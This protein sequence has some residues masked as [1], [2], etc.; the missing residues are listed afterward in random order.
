MGSTGVKEYV[1]KINGVTQSVKDVTSLESAVKA[2]DTAVKEVNTN[3]AK[4]STASKQKAAAMTDEEKA[5]KKLA[6]TQK[7]IAAANSEANRAQIAATQELRE[8]TREITRQVAAEKLAEDSVKAMGM[9]LTDLRN[10][11][12]ALSAAERNEHEV[13]GVL[14]ERIQALDSEYK[15]LRES[16]GNF[17]DSV[18]HY[19]KAFSGL[20]E[21]KDRFELASRGSAN[22]A[23]EVVGTND[24]L[25]AFGSTTTTVAKSAEQLA[26]ITA[27]AT[28]AQEAYNAVVKEGWI[29]QQAAAVMDAVRAVQLKAKTAAEA[30]STK[31]TIAATVA[32]KALNIVANA[33]PYVLLATAIVTV[34]GALYMFANRT[35]NAAEKQK[36]LNEVQ[37]VFLDQ[38]ERE[39]N[40]LKEAGDARVKA[41]QNQLAVLQ[42]AG[43]KTNDIRAIEDKLA[44]EREAN[45]SRQRGFYAEE[46]DNLDKN[47][48]KLEELHDVLDQLKTAQASGGTK[49]KLDI[50]LDGKV[51]KVKVEDAINSVQGA[52]DN[53]GRKVKI[54]VDLQAEDK[55]IQQDIAVQNAARIKA[56]A[57]LAKERA[58]K[59][60]EAAKQRADIETTETRAAQDKR[61]ELIRDSYDK[62]QQ[63]IF[64][65]YQREIEDLQKKLATEKNLTAKA[66][67]AI[68]DQI[69][70]AEARRD[71]DIEKL[72][73]E[74]AVKELADRRAAE[75][76]HTALIQ[77]A[78]KR[79]ETEINIRYER[80]KHD[81]QLRLDTEEDLTEAQQKDITDQME[82]AQ[83][84]R[85]K[86]LKELA[87]KGLEDRAA[88]ELTA[89]D[90][91][92][93]QAKDRIG[94]L[95]KRDKGSLQLIDVNA[96]RD[97]LAAANAV[98]GEYITGM[99]KY[100]ADLQTAHEAT[101]ATLKKGTPEYIAEVLKYAQAQEAV[102][103]RIKKAQEEQDQ[104]T[105]Q[106]TQTQYRYYQELFGKIADYAQEGSEIVGNAMDVW[107]QGLQAQV[108][109][110][111]SQLD[112]VNE[113]YEEAQKM[114]EDAAK[115]VEDL[116]SRIQNATGGA[117]EAL[118]EQ[119]ADQMAARNEA[120]REEDRLEREKEKKEADIAKKEKQM[121]RNELISNIAMAIANTAQGATKALAMGPIL[122]PI[123]A[124][125]VTGIG[126]VQVAL[127]TKQL[128]KLADGGPIIG[129]S[130]ANGG[131][132]IGMGYEAE[133]GEYV[134]NKQSYA[135]NK[136]LVEF[137][138]ASE[139]TITAADLVG[140]LPDDTGAPIV[141]NASQSSE[142]RIVEAIENI[143]MRP[144]VAVTD[145]MD[146]QDQVVTVRDLSGF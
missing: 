50:D 80:Q 32:Q 73:N 137:I 17:R 112:A 22:L 69:V 126:A 76:A 140:V 51:E 114:H 67:A 23:A 37:A 145:I 9:R 70:S 38:L 122:G 14:L 79:Q 104:N 20:N 132:N 135:A 86:A 107:N 62:E 33:N 120:A 95:T 108:D 54:A 46:I 10:E 71:A 102:T 24:V 99:L 18:G 39:S 40:R 52:I 131:V 96:T 16:T 111:N 63:T 12:E 109:E 28:T 6:D 57:D 2:L 41:L 36:T 106:S 65:Q 143:D 110:L 1:I 25:D 134:T 19:E 142:D 89:L 34:A 97:N 119:L 59:A 74:H 90:F 42:A 129:P 31:G 66:R 98:L 13:G 45:N 144:T 61:I 75:D 55:D 103:Q 5:V 115:S 121:K 146:V 29:Q 47:K 77:G 60:K 138:N 94:K 100:G 11:Y 64:A 127:M 93:N 130:H 141:V 26:G 82:A 125:L 35:S 21:L 72:H 117:A 118:K 92:L 113:R 43:A 58:E 81:L 8:R 128:T 83:L 48:K 123:L 139:G 44:K 3:T 30:L 91:S 27:L 105:K 124:A 85:D 56:D 78:T 84:A 15:A 133:G 136:P 68:N 7:K 87:A 101:L 116:E 4:A 53:L 88:Q 49:V